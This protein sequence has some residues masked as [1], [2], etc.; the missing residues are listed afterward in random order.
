MILTLALG[1]IALAGR[2]SLDNLNFSKSELR[3]IDK[4]AKE[5]S[6]KDQ[7]ISSG[8][9]QQKESRRA[10]SF[11]LRIFILARRKTEGLLSLF[12][13]LFLYIS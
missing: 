4:K 2:E 7:K 8:K 9:S 11:F 13:A 1:A 3:E 5:G 12:R 10:L 6:K